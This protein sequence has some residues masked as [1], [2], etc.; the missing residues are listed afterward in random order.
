MQAGL[1]AVLSAKPLPDK[2]NTPR[3]RHDTAGEQGN[4]YQEQS[5]AGHSAT[6]SPRP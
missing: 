2:L 4:Q 5:M 6:R 1:G 3:P